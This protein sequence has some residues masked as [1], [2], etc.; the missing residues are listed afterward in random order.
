MIFENGQARVRNDPDGE[1]RYL[2]QETRRSYG[3]SA[4]IE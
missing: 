1:A 3:T 4:G 2:V